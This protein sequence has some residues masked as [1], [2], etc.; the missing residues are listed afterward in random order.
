MIKLLSQRLGI[1]PLPTLFF[2]VWFALWC[3]WWNGGFR[4]W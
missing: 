1:K 4:W 3:V 2:I